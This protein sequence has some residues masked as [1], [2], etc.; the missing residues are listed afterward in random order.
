M[1]DPIGILIYG[2]NQEDTLQIRIAFDQAVAD[3]VFVIS[4]SE[5]EDW[6]I[7]D[8]LDQGPEDLYEDKDDKIVIFLAFSKEQVDAALNAFPS[9]GVTRPIFCGLTIKNMQWPLRHLIGHLKEEHKQWTQRDQNPP[10]ES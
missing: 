3:S 8:I 1:K 5:K 2:Y 7:V 4:G 6:L 9:P 10:G